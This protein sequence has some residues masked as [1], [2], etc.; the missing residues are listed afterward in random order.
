MTNITENKAGGM[1]SAIKTGSVWLVETMFL[2]LKWYKHVCCLHLH[3]W[4][5]LS[6]LCFTWFIINLYS[7]ENIIIVFMSCCYLIQN[8]LVHKIFQ[9]HWGF[10]LAE[11]TCT[12]GHKMQS[13]NWQLYMIHFQSTNT[14]IQLTIIH[15]TFSENQHSHTIIHDTFSEN[16][17][18]H[19]NN[20]WYIFR[21]PTQSYNWQ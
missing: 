13:Y 5:Y 18:S 1:G 10:F 16:Q 15:D 19:D 11:I 8:L 4:N 9:Y 2:A 20:T 7:D 17:H 21:K 3:S 14:V 6:T 12:W